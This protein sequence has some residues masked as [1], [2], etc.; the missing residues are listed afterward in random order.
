MYVA[1]EKGA[2]EGKPFVYYL[3]YLENKGYVAP[4]MRTWLDLIRQHG[5]ESAHSLQIPDEK[6][7]QS[8]FTFTAELL[9]LIYEMEFLANKFTK[10]KD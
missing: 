8:T 10:P 2:M 6:R 7:A 1:A 5:N 9:R 3:D 4:Q